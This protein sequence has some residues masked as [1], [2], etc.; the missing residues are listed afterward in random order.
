MTKESF[1]YARRCLVCVM[2]LSPQVVTE[3]LYCLVTEQNF[4]PTEVILLTTLNG[5][6]RALRDLLDPQDGKFAAFCRDYNLQGKIAFS[7]ESIHVIKDADGL[8]LTD[9][10]TPQDN[11]NAA[12]MIAS[13]VGTLCSDDSTTLHVSIAGGRKTM[14]FFLGYALSIFGRQQ[15]RMSHVLVSEPYENNKD[16]FYPTQTPR[17]IYHADGSPLDASKAK[18]SLAEIPFIKLRAGLSPELLS[19]A[20]RYSYAVERAQKELAPGLSLLLDIG[21]RTAVC[22]GQSVKLPPVLFSVYL[23]LAQRTLQ[24]K[25]AARPGENVCADEMLRV[26]REVVGRG[27][28]DYDNAC[29]ALKREEDFLPYFQEKR[30]LINR[31]LKAQLGGYKSE[32]YKIKSQGKRLNLSYS[33]SLKPDEIQILAKNKFK[34]S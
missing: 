32:N 27:S 26:Y 13:V 29:A 24:G 4:V 16:F 2:G 19:G 20:C 34:K 25:D 22:A 10:R 1:E 9:I 28:A 14:G 33:L 11:I 8:P 6:N 31:V 3:T 7:E 17:E 18:V 12:D 5:K 15:D 21:S 30:S 23:W